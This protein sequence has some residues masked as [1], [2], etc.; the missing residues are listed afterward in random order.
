MIGGQNEGFTRG[1]GM[2]KGVKLGVKHIA[3]VSRRTV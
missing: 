2:R 3:D 1:E